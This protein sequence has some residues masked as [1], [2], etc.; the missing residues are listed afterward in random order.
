MGMYAAATCQGH[1]HDPQVDLPPPRMIDVSRYAYTILHAGRGRPI[2][3]MTA[4]QSLG[5]QGDSAPQSVS[6]QPATA[7]GVFQSRPDDDLDTVLAS[8]EMESLLSQS[9][10]QPAQRT[11]QPATRAGHPP[12][13][14]N[15]PPARHSPEAGPH[16]A[17]S[18]Q[19]DDVVVVAPDMGSVEAP[20][21][22]E[23]RDS[24]ATTRRRQQDRYNGGQQQQQQAS[25]SAWDYPQQSRPR[26]QPAL[27]KEVVDLTG[28]D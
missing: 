11:A 19:D 24:R 8:P 23:I 28:D 6:T 10:S 26:R 3:R 14:S 16:P 9:Q 17:T 27:D 4:A 5:N 22:G 21:P 20:S 2:R 7:T 1:P 18:S 15:P 12:T 13:P 25:A